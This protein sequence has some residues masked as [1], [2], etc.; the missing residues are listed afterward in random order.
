LTAAV[1]LALGFCLVHQA[2]VLSGDA[3]EDWTSWTLYENE[4]F[5]YEVEYPRVLSNVGEPDNDDGVELA[6]EDGNYRLTI[7]GGYN[8]LEKDAET[9]LEDRLKEASRIRRIR[10]AF[11]DGWYRAVF[12]DGGKDGN[13]R[14]YHEYGVIDEDNWASFILVYPKGEENRFAEI[15]ARMEKS[16]A[17]PRPGE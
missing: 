10:D 15:T 7:S 17:L 6:S 8:V 11:G 5:G 12:S 3:A 2:W 13:E 9:T 4:R 1:F 14:L 16:L